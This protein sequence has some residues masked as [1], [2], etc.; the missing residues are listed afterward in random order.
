MSMPLN[1]LQLIPTVELLLDFQPED[2][3]GEAGARIPSSLAHAASGPQAVQ[4]QPAGTPQQTLERIVR[5]TAPGVSRRR[6]RAT[7][8]CHRNPRHRGIGVWARLRRL[9]GMG[10]QASKNTT[11]GDFQFTL[12]ALAEAW[13]A[14]GGRVD[15]ACMVNAFLRLMDNREAVPLCTSDVPDGTDLR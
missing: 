4:R 8:H 2:L 12:F 6:R 14:R 7:M 3:G 11:K 10:R 13:R 1:I 5:H 15:N 9:T